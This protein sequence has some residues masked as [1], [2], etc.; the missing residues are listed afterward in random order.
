MVTVRVF[1][2][3]TEDGDI[4]GCVVAVGDSGGGSWRIHH[5]SRM[6]TMWWRC[7]GV[8]LMVVVG[9]GCKKGGGRSD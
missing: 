9:G 3:L 7:C 4:R 6:N 2:I 5:R 8:V 1:R